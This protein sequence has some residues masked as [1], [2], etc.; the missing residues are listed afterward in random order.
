M[1]KHAYYEENDFATKFLVILQEKIQRENSSNPF[2]KS[3]AAQKQRRHSNAQPQRDKYSHGSNSSNTNNK[4]IKLKA[5]QTH[6]NDKNTKAESTPKDKTTPSQHCPVLVTTSL[7]TASKKT[8]SPRKTN[9]IEKN[10][11]LNLK[12]SKNI[13]NGLKRNSESDKI[14]KDISR[15]QLRKSEGNSPEVKGASRTILDVS[16]NQPGKNLPEICSS[17]NINRYVLLV[18]FS[19]LHYISD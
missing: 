4:N 13:S 10:N 19:K 11:E 9:D 1:M 15:S 5:I 14:L 12:H 2:L 6:Q 17:V 16:I 3:L 8:P 18:L 7:K